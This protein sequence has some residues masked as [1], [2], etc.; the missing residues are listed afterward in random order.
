MIDWIFEIQAMI[1]NGISVTDLEDRLNTHFGNCSFGVEGDQ[2]AVG[3][4]VNLPYQSQVWDLNWKKGEDIRIT[5]W[6]Y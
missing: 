2:E 4:N 1:D 6:P 5:R 3:A